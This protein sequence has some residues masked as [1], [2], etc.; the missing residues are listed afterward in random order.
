M[1]NK[2]LFAILTLVCFMFTLMPVAAFAEET[3]AAT[4]WIEVADT[5]WYTSTDSVYTINTAEE[6]AGIAKLVNNGTTTFSNETIELGANIDLGGKEWT[7]IGPSTTKYFNGTFDG[8][9]HN[10][11]NLTIETFQQYG[12][13]F[14]QNLLG[15]AV[16]KNIT[17]SNAKVGKTGT[18]NVIAIVS[19]YA[20]GT[21]TFESVAIENSSV[22]G[23]GKVSPILGMAADESGTTT[24]KNCHVRD[25]K[26][27]GGY[28][29]GALCGYLQN[30]ISVE[31][32]T[33]NAT[34]QIV[35]NGY[36]YAE[37]NSVCEHGDK[38]AGN[39]MIVEDTKNNVSYYYG[40]VADFYVWEN[41]ECNVQNDANLVYG[42][43]RNAEAIVDDIKYM[44]L[45]DAI[46]AAESGDTVTLLAD[47]ELNETIT[48]AE[49]KN[50]TLDLNGRAITVGWDDES[51][52]KHLYAFDNQG[53]FALTDSVGTGSITARGV[54]NYGTMVMNGGTIIACDTNGGYGVWNYGNFTMNDGTVKVTHVGS[55]N[56][57]YG[58][59]GLGNMSGATMT[60][61]GGNIEGAS[62]R[63]YALSSEGT[64]NIT[65]AE[66]KEVTLKA[67]RGVAI[68]AGTAVING[69]T[70][71]VT[72][73]RDAA[74]ETY[75]ALYISGGESVIVNGGTFNAPHQSVWNT[76]EGTPLTINGGTFN[77][78]LT[79]GLDDNHEHISKA[80]TVKGGTF[81]VDPTEFVATG[82]NA[83]AVGGKYVVVTNT[84]TDSGSDT[85]DTLVAAGTVKGEGDNKVVEVE[86][87]GTY[88]T[89]MP[90]E[91]VAG[92]V[93]VESNT[94]KV[95]ATTPQVSGG[96]ETE[97]VA[98]SV[99]LPKETAASMANAANDTKL[100]VAAD[101]ATVVLDKNA[102]A[103]VAAEAAEQPAVITIEENANLKEDITTEVNGD[104]V[105]PATVVDIAVKVGGKEV[106]AEDAGVTT[107][108][109]ITVKTDI[110]DDKAFVYY[111]TDENKLTEGQEVPVTDGVV[112]FTTDHLSSY[113]IFATK[114]AELE[115][116]EPEEDTKPST[117]TG[118]GGFSGSYN[119]PVNAGDVDGAKVSFSD[120][121]AVAG[122]KVT[123]T[124]T[125]D[126]GK[127]VDEVIVTDKDGKVIPVT[128]VGDNQY[129]FTMPAGKV[130]VSVTT[131]AI[132]Y[133]S[134][135]VLQI[136]N[137]N[138]VVDGKTI[139]NDV[140][141]TIVGDRTMVPLRVI[142]EALGGSV[143]WDEATRT[144]TI[145][146]DGKV[147]KLVIDQPIPGF[148][149]GAV[150]MDSRTMVPIR[151]IA[152]YVGAHV[153][154]IEATQQIVIL[155]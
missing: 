140:A 143:D 36:E 34:T 129:S 122:E 28:N 42:I 79:D 120:N 3:S 66:G 155:K 97:T 60:I 136:N 19:G 8:K 141:P 59:T 119:Y 111:V 126:A 27:V 32:C 58:P 39:Y 106:L 37:V 82:Y 11:S 24:F 1:K 7:P 26:I 70:F 35:S 12:N 83:E 52:G 41:G 113:A 76:S 103:A 13:G 33:T 48:I 109:T 15:G 51:N 71:T 49:G 17:F 128:K 98:A 78:S 86:I 154:W 47:T 61:T 14:F 95:D 55:S 142:V 23:F 116:V 108:I 102:L 46:A 117:S 45:A 65:P 132:D 135:I 20:Y 25:T 90:E 2:K 40:G 18:G 144:V 30:D 150:I 110:T 92:D 10:I 43:N 112:T 130:N 44:T 57:Q 75:Y 125:P 74:A 53:T 87:K 77:A 94:V 56:D 99:S 107:E 115:P 64:L 5:S 69:G 152:E 139:T 134:K 54:K 29:I 101:A 131:E 124:V 68:D 50:I 38:V 118:G 137:K 148:G 62:A 147:M 22:L 100:E 121:N 67:P 91:N 93:A 4:N 133:D 153:D 89:N 16:V 151:Y 31:N 21:V 105:A 114:V 73:A 138:V 72:D 84:S 9:N 63:A 6:L 96:A 81:K 80:I 149:Q 127:Q 85:V 123:I 88:S 104:E 145:T 146:I